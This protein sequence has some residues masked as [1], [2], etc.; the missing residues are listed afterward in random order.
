QGDC[1]GFAACAATRHYGSGG[2]PIRWR[3]W[4]KGPSFGWVYGF[5]MA[6]PT[7]RVD[8]NLFRVMD[9]VYVHGGISG[10]ARHLHLSQPAVSHAGARLGRLWGDALFVRHGNSM[11]P[12]ELTRRV[13]GEEQAHLR[14]LQTLVA[15]ADSFDPQTLDM[16]I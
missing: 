12:S 8:L 1:S 9:A 7:T 11:V 10:A 4:Q 13:S 6:I 15:Q 16:T 5:G 2:L 3:V 14:G